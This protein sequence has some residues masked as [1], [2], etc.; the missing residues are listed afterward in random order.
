MTT[1][2][3]SLP[4]GAPGWRQRKMTPNPVALAAF[5]CGA[6][7]LLKIQFVGELYAA[8]LLLLLAALL[9]VFSGGATRLLNQR[10][11]WLFLVFLGMTLG[12]YVISD[13]I[14]ESS[15]AQY[16]R[17]W[18]RVAFLATDIFALTLL[19]ARDPRNLWWFVLGLGVGGVVYLRLTGMPFAMWKFGYGV[20][21]ML[22]VACAGYWLPPRM[23][24]AAM[25]T[26][27]IY[28]ILVDSR[29][30][31]AVCLMVAAVVWVRAAKLNMPLDRSG[32]LLRLGAAAG[33]A[34]LV[35][36][37]LLGSTEDQYSARRDASNFGRSVGIRVGLAAVGESPI[38][39]WGSWSDSRELVRLTREAIREESKSSGVEY[40]GPEGLIFGAH[41][42][43]LQS[44]VEGGI[45]G[46]T[47][48]AFFGFQLL[49]WLRYTVMTRPLDLYSPIFLTYLIYQFWHLIQSPL[50]Q[51]QRMHVATAI[52]I[53]VILAAE[54][55]GRRPAGSAP[56][57]QPY[58]YGKRAAA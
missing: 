33:L 55:A 45:L 26:V 49:R 44:W 14:R 22:A 1:V 41:S 24:A 16:L 11:F 9:A 13:L 47:F 38:I 35:F 40:Y 36:W 6:L 27:G 48:F 29:I 12:G 54:K 4:A 57:R 50:G 21:V 31:G 15:P 51:N 10:L 19:A 34:F 39:G 18:A 7:G 56:S 53:M 43:I 28:S 25:G 42:Q 37:G 23:A 52:V 2:P 17:G 20:P 58:P 3:N 5:C 8:E 32:R 46:A 30:Q